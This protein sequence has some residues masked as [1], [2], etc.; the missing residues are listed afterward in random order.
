MIADFGVSVVLHDGV[1][2][3][4]C[5]TPGYQAPEVLLGLPY[6]MAVDWWSLGVMAHKMLVEAVSTSWW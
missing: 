5:G 6:S 2:H 1:A 4:R 3:T